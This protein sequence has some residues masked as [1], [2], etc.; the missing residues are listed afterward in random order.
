MA[1]NPNVKFVFCLQF[2]V[3]INNNGFDIRQRTDSTIGY[4]H[5]YECDLNNV[6]ECAAERI[7]N[8]SRIAVSPID[9]IWNKLGN[10]NWG[11]IAAVQVLFATFHCIMEFAGMPKHSIEDLAADHGSRLQ[12]RRVERELEDTRVNGNGVYWYQNRTVSPEIV[13][14][15]EESNNIHSMYF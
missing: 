8:H 2:R 13:E 12:T 15:Q 14:V 7:K 6:Y 11:D 1:Y 9:R 5:F 3:L 10:A 4:G